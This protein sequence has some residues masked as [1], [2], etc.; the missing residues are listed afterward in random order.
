MVL[1]SLTLLR[2]QGTSWKQIF[3]GEMGIIFVN[4]R[5]WAPANDKHLLVTRSILKNFCNFKAKRF[6]P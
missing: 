1:L 5:N 3:R 6:A 4:T 2:L